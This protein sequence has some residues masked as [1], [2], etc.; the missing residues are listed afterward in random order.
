MTN[1]DEPTPYKT[2]PEPE[3]APQPEPQPWEQ[4]ALNSQPDP[5]A[6]A[7]VAPPSGFTEGALTSPFVEGA[8]APSLY[9]DEP[10][11]PPP[12]PLVPSEPSY[13]PLLYPT[14][15]RQGLFGW[16]GTSVGLATGVIIGM[17]LVVLF[18]WWGIQS[19]IF[20]D[21]FARP[22]G[23]VT[24]IISVNGAP[25]ATPVL[26]V[27]TGA[28]T[29]TPLPVVTTTPGVYV[30]ATPAPHPTPVPGTTPAPQA[31]ST[32]QPTIPPT[33]TPSP[34]TA[35]PPPLPLTVTL[36]YD[37]KRMTMTVHV[38]SAPNATL[39]I[40]VMDCDGVTDP[41]APTSGMT[42]PNGNYQSYP[43]K[44]RIPQSCNTVTA[45]VTATHGSQ[46]GTGSTTFAFGP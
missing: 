40:S 32:P 34:P 39:S 16:A 43:W 33:A 28:A 3:Q 22:A 5:A 1:P 17:L 25:T 37:H 21:A 27:G 31:T 35:T 24:T 14:H 41:Q 9:P 30:T 20:K 6:F 15:P 12:P 18:A 44:A 42:D 46:Q 11:A 38:Q 45:T 4:P 29:A 36:N 13:Y 8:A 10:S 26:G 2:Q 23:T 19:G 7:H